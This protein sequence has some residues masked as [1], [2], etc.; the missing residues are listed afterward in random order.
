MSAPRSLRTRLIVGTIAGI[1][2]FLAADGVLVY[3]LVK[4]R[5]VAEV[6]RSLES[7]AKSLVAT[8]N[9]ELGRRLRDGR[10]RIEDDL[11][12]PAKAHE[13]DALFQCWFEDGTVLVRSVE[14]GDRELP[15]LP[16]GDEAVIRPID[17]PDGSR[18]RAVSLS[19]VPG[20]D[21][22]REG[23]RPR[24]GRDGERPPRR[25]HP[26]VDAERRPVADR[27]R[28]PRRGDDDRR[29]PGARLRP[30]GGRQRVEIVAARDLGTVETTLR[31]LRSVLLITWLAASG[32]CAAIVWGV[33]ALGLRPIGR[34]RSQLSKVD[35]RRLD[36]RF[37]VDRAPAEL[38]PVVD[39][40]NAFL[41]RI[42]E[43]FDRE[44]TFAAHAAHEL[45]TPLAGLR[46]TLE[47]TASKPR[48]AEDYREAVCDC[49]GITIQMQ[50]VV[51]ALLELA[52]PLRP[53]AASAT[54]DVSLASLV[55]GV[56]RSLATEAAAREIHL[57]NA[58]DTSLTV[59]T[60]E[61][62]LTRVVTNLVANAIAHGDAT[63]DIR[64]AVT[65]H[66]DGTVDLVVGNRLDD[67]PDELA[68][69][70]F[71]AF[72]RA[73]TSRTSRAHAGLGLAICKRIAGALDLTITA[74][75]EV[76]WFEV[77]LQG[78]ATR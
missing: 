2:L 57:E 42:Q 6:D 49:L 11:G 31:D 58:I 68:E 24:R 40:L 34:L 78:L 15:R 62:L 7:I 36:H 59:R 18:G 63:S 9:L 20:P 27:D 65:V 77:R 29:P 35:E 26:G 46:S 17:M 44:Q 60:D 30:G 38:V 71:D 13:V 72:W 28:P 33:V 66:E 76:G 51:E 47:V 61:R 19:I 50:S 54:T 45:R 8:V 52:R 10:P 3:V 32:G 23:E 56:W 75:H 48:E 43:A 12:I 14:L 70:A 25:P 41:A 73:D 55:D 21:H 16:A 5:L 74:R 53:D 67:A 4:S 69:R 64:V 39:Q 22:A 1:T 37:A